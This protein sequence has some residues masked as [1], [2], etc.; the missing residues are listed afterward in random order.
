MLLKY[1]KKHL[2]YNTDYSEKR[3]FL[4]SHLQYIPH[5]IILLVHCV[6]CKYSVKQ[7]LTQTRFVQSFSLYM[8]VLV[9]VKSVTLI[10]LKCVIQF[11]H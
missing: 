10:T 3:C 2:S 6:L 4:F 5:K 11:H 8:A 9:C 7:R 1:L